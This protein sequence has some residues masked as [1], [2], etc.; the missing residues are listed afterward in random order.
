[1]TNPEDCARFKKIL[2][3]NFEHILVFQKLMQSEALKYPLIDFESAHGAFAKLQQEPAAPGL[4][5][6]PKA[7]LELAYIKACERGKYKGL[8]GSLMRREFLEFTCR[9]A[10]AFIR[11]NNE[12]QRGLLMSDHLQHFID[13]HIK[14]ACRH[15]K[16][17]ET[18]ATIRG[19]KRLNE[20]LFDN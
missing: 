11:G 20:L 5:V 1:M 17:H 15:L 13:T 16:V 19:S 18:R 7:H 9:V 8:K 10:V 4:F 3:D 2:E 12:R 6:L 14:H